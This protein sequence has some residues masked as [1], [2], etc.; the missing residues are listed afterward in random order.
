MLGFLPLYQ[1]KPDGSSFYLT[2]QIEYIF[3]GNPKNI[4][5][6]EQSQYGE[7]KIIP[8]ND[9]QKLFFIESPLRSIILNEKINNVKENNMFVIKLPKNTIYIAYP[10]S[11]ITIEK[12][13]NNFII[14]KIYGKNEYYKPNDD[15]SV[16]IDNTNI[17][18]QKNKSDFSL[19]YLINEYE[20][21]KIQYIIDQAGGI[22]ITQP[23]YQKF[24]KKILDI[25][26]IIR[27]NIYKENLEN[28]ELYKDFFGRKNIETNYNKEENWRNLMLELI[29]KGRQETR[30]FK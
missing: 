13:G 7:Q 22:I 14:T 18:E 6:T 9:N 8:N 21:S 23:I 28:Y 15:T 2:Q 3:L 4:E 20:N 29:Q 17:Q 30:H 12:N 5:I 10:G 24:S 1:Q 26:Y 27:P 16:Y 25:A 19:N 11:K